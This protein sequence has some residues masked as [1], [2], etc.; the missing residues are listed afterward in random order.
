MVSLGNFQTLG[1]V[2]DCFYHAVEVG[3]AVEVDVVDRVFVGVKYTV[4]AIA[5]RVENVAVECETVGG[6]S[7]IIDSEAELT[8]KTKCRELLIRV[9]ELQDIAYRL[10]CLEV[11]VA[12]QV[13]TVEGISIVGLAI[14]QSE[15][16]CDGQV[17]LTTSKYVLQESVPFLYLC[18]SEL[19]LTVLTLNNWRLEIL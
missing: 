13:L 9:V 5:F 7:R 18:V 3:R 2:V 15:V 8:T 10:Q 1:H 6:S 17:Y 11:L 12:A 4:E 16:D 19:E 14:A